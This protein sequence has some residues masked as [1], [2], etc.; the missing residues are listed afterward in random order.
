MSVSVSDADGAIAVDA[1]VVTVVHRQQCF[2]A[3]IV[4]RDMW[5]IQHWVQVL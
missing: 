2:C 4:M 5:C 3:V 1:V